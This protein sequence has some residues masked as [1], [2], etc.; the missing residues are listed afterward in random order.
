[1]KLSAQLETEEKKKEMQVLV[2][3]LQYKNVEICI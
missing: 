2:V 1:M 3:Q